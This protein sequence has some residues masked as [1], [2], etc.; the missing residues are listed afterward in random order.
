M[1]AR[2]DWL[3]FSFDHQYSDFFFDYL[4]KKLGTDFV[5]GKSSFHEQHISWKGEGVHLFL[6]PKKNVKNLPMLEVSG[7]GFRF[8]DRQEFFLEMLRF[9]RGRVCRIDVCWDFYANSFR[10]DEFIS[11]DMAR[12]RPFRKGARRRMFFDEKEFSGFTLG[13][14]KGSQVAVRVYDKK[15]E[16]KKKYQGPGWWRVEIGIR[17]KMAKAQVAWA[18]DWALLGKYFLSRKIKIKRLEKYSSFQGGIL[19]GQKVRQ[20]A[21]SS[22]QAYKKYWERLHAKSAETLSKIR[23]AEVDFHGTSSHI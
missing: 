18:S 10:H 2:L 12:L 20:L 23:Q 21:E 11:Q 22:G 8:E 19:V 1:V 15:R 7:V 17:G 14:G 9:C 5:L 16:Q 6:M 3:A 13:Y 4:T